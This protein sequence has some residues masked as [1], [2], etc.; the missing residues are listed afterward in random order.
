MPRLPANALSSLRFALTPLSV[1]LLTTF[2]LAADALDVVPKPARPSATQPTA[3]PTSRPVL[4]DGA[5]LPRL[6]LD[7][8]LSETRQMNRDAAP[9][10][11]RADRIDGSVD[12][13]VLLTGNAEVRRGGV[14]L[15]GDRILYTQATDQ[16]DVSGNARVFGRGATFSGPELSFRIDAQTGSMPNAQFT[17]PARNGRGEATLVEFLSEQRARM[18]NA[19]FT[20][21]APGDKSWWVQLDEV[22]IDGLEQSA[23]ASGAVLYFQ[24]VPILASPWFGFPVGNQR[25]TGFLTPS[26]GV[27][28][29][30]GTDIRT[31]FYWNI[32]P[33]YDYTA[34]PRILSKRGV[35]LGNE[36]RFLEREYNGTLLYDI[37]PNDRETGTARSYTGAR[38]N[39]N[40]PTGFGA[41][42]NYNRVSDDNY[43][44]DFSSTILG[45]SQKV[46][47]QDAFLSYTQPFWNAVARVTKNQIL[48]DPL[49]PV[50]PPYERVPQV[51]VTGFVAD[52]RGWEA[53]A[54]LD[55]TRF[56]NP[57]ASL[58]PGTRYIA[59][60]R[61]AYPIIAPGWFITPRAQISATYYSLDPQFNPGNT[62]DTRVMPILSLDS[63]L[64]FERDAQWFGRASQQTLEPRVFYA[65]IPFRAQNQLPNFDSA[66]ADLNYAQ[67]FTENIYS[68]YDRIVN[69]NQLTLA[70]ATRILDSETG[71]ERLRAA[72]GQR[73]YFTEQKVT[74]PGESPRQGSESDLLAAL[75]AQLGG[76]WAVD[77][78]VQY[79]AETSAIS[80]A[81]A[82][83]RW[84]PRRSS[85]LSA[86]YRYQE[87]STP[88][89][90]TNQIDVSAQWPITDRWYGVGRYNYSLQ[91][92]KVVE[93]IAG[94]EYK[95]D[96]WVLRFAFQRFQTTTATS[97]TNFYV[98]LELTGLTS[99]GTNALSQLQ[100]NIPGY[101]RINPLP[102]QP[103]MFEYYE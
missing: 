69:A 43:F 59:N 46:L 97:T 101:Q 99:V 89:S 95:E 72:V 4:G 40:S 87:S 64:I 70:L 68:G 21:C 33:N 92:R 37:I 76:N 54:V 90:S 10:F 78:A 14:V 22:S 84:Q 57:Q 45:S 100:R 81:T 55:A 1:A 9:T 48:Q 29:T 41:G 39:W 25:R 20:T 88:S 7:R 63:G 58:Q 60:P 65:Y 2:P 27:S 80:R 31:P 36:F 51:A 28:N 38:F 103:G 85:V 102:R 66:L 73:Y 6:K 62:S 56:T 34:T 24:G 13:S 44:V 11:A 12:E 93:A 5:S 94:F 18:E 83:V 47:P 15:R 82:G 23:T 30:L 86:Y 79:S 75:A 3:P 16:V 91:N 17:Y 74:L 53:A 98:Q 96:C 67:F 8:A 77:A 26:F 35:L 19:R 42:V 61:V 71:A 52:W 32:A 50:T 49:A